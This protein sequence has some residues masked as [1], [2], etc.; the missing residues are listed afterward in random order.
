[1]FLI[2][3][4]TEKLKKEVTLCKRRDDLPDKLSHENMLSSRVKRSSLL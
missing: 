4:T 2:V 3:E 1:M